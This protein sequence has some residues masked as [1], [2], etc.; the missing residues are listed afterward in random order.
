MSEQSKS[1]S[2]GVSSCLKILLFG[3]NLL[4]ILIPLFGIHDWF[5]FKHVVFSKYT[6]CLM[7]GLL[8]KLFSCNGKI[9]I[10]G[11]VWLIQDWAGTLDS[12]Q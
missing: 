5:I 11:A 9:H 12:V 10:K 8:G 4:S 3:L 6:S 7:L 2:Q 1:Y